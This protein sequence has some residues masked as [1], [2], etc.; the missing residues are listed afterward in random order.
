DKSRTVS[1]AEGYRNSLI[2]PANGQ[3]ERMLR[4]AEGYEGKVINRAQGE[5]QRFL[6]MLAE[7][8]KTGGS[9]SPDVTRERLYLETMEKIMP[10]VK[11]YILN[12][13]NKNK[14]NLRF[15]GDK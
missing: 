3:A 2:P 6:S 14:V 10:R 8:R 15:L 13:D 9:A 5:T 12:A 1:Q 4:E 11:K 7:Y